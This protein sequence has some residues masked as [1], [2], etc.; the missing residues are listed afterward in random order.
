MV[1]D[2]FCAG[3]GNVCMFDLC[4]GKGVCVYEFVEFGMFCLSDGNECTEDWCDD[5]G[6][7][8]YLFFLVG[9]LC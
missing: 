7:C 1:A 9:T 8:R 4:D 2:I 5:Q 3:D 6:E